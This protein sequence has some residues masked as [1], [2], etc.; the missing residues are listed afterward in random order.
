MASYT[1]ESFELLQKLAI[2][3][4][5]KLQTLHIRADRFHSW[6]LEK[7]EAHLARLVGD[8]SFLADLGKANVH[9]LQQ[10][11]WNVQSYQTL[12]VICVDS[13]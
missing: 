2:V 13:E 7:R 8:T 5:S 9:L 10:V 1:K 3:D 11:R 4:I 12:N 6:L